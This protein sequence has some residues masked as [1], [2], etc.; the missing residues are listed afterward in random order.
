MISFSF[1]ITNNILLLILGFIISRGT[2]FPLLE[3]SL[4]WFLSIV[5]KILKFLKKKWL[6]SLFIF[7]YNFTAILFY[8]LSGIL[9]IP[10]FVAPLIMGFSIGSVA[11]R[12]LPEDILSGFHVSKY[13]FLNLAAILVPIIELSVFIWA[14][15]LGEKIAFDIYFFKREIGKTVLSYVFQYAKFA[16]LPLLISAFLEMGSIDVGEE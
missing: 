4:A 15:A 12:R 5:S 13:K 8:M 14:V 1:L 6:M 3:N 2:R 7:A 9:F 16:P 10:P 11:F